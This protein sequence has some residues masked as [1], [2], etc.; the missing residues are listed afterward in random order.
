MQE[1]DILVILSTENTTSKY[2]LTGK[3]FDCIRS[4][5]FVLGIANS[6]NVNYRLLIEE[7]KIGEGCFNEVSEILNILNNQYEIWNQKNTVNNLDID[8]KTYS[9]RNQN[10]NL[11]TT[12][13]EILEIKV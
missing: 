3:L 6:D 9:R 7:L 2:T 4:G 5:K 8:K 1:S 13:N 10:M 12:L 11:I